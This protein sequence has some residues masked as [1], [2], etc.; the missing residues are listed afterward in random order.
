MI[1]TTVMICTLMFYNSYEA[2]QN[3][4]TKKSNQTKKKK[5]RRKEKDA[6]SCGLK[7]KSRKLLFV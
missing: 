2:K 4:Q 6:E 5:K 7:R 1:Q 3:K